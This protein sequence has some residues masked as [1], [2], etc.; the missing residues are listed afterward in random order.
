MK[1]KNKDLVRI[2]GGFHSGNVGEVIG[3]K[4]WYYKKYQVLY[5]WISKK[6]ESWHTT[7]WV[8]EEDLHPGENYIKLAKVIE[9]KK[10]G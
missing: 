2:K 4:G 9:I 5:Y 7:T 1:Y 6:G 10:H 3:I 8:K